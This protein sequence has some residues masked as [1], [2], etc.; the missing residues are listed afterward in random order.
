MLLLVMPVFFTNTAGGKCTSGPLALT[1]FFSPVSRDG[2]LPKIYYGGMNG[3]ITTGGTLGPTS[4]TG[5][6]LDTL[7]LEA[8][9]DPAIW[10][11]IYR[12]YLNF[13]TTLN[14]D[15]TSQNLFAEFW[16]YSTFS[17]S[18]SGSMPIFSAYTPA[19]TPV[20]HFDFGVFYDSVTNRCFP[21]IVIGNASYKTNINIRP[22]PA[23][24]ARWHHLA[25]AIRPGD[26]GVYIYVD[27]VA[28]QPVDPGE[29]AAPIPSYPSDAQLY[30][31]YTTLTG[32]APRGAQS[33]ITTEYIQDARVIKGGTP[34]TTNFTPDKGPWP[35]GSVPSYAPGGT[36]ILGLDAQYFQRVSFTNL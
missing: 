4:N 31:G 32:G 35:L 17:A 30:I 9:P 10:T 29:A 8:D 34:T 23:T 7:N 20:R 2:S 15:W 26:P 11:P 22:V 1:Q 16:I 18:S 28:Q 14:F 19:P 3:I 6:L 27:G 33:I 36:N 13:G 25:V 5:I 21:F 12:N 24:T